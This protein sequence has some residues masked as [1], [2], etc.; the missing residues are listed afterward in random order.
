MTYVH[1]TLIIPA[2]ITPTCQQLSVALSGEAGSNMWLTGLSPTG[3]EPPTHYISSGMITEEFAT[4]IADPQVMFDACTAM[5]LPVTLEQ[6]QGIL[7]MADVSEDGAFEAMDRLGLKMMQS[8]LDQE[9][10]LGA[11]L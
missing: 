3:A 9:P 8:V 4:M 10:P 7:G 5:E 2:A 6:C 11:I 1:R